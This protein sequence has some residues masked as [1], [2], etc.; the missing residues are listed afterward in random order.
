MTPAYS[1]QFQGS[2]ALFN[3]G[4]LWKA[5]AESKVNFFGWT[6]MHRKIPTADNLEARGMQNNHY[7]PLCNVQ[8]EMLHTSSGMPIPFGGDAANLDIV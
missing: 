6:A 7:C 2:H 8:A 3:T 4:K 1:I 5:K